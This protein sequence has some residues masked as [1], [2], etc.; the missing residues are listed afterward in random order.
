MPTLNRKLLLRLFLATL[1]LG[2]GLLLLHYVQSDR[3]KDALRWQADHAAENGRLDKA[4]LYMR[5]YLELRPEDHDAAVRLGELILKRGSGQKELT[6]ALFLYERVLR[7]APEREDVRRRLVDICVRLGRYGDGMIHA[8]ALLDRAPNES[9]LWEQ[10]GVCQAGLNQPDE[11]RASFEKAVA[12]DSARIRGYELLIDLLGRQLSRP[13]EAKVWADRMVAANPKVADA[14]IV[15]ARFLRGQRKLVECERDVEALLALEPASADG[16]LLRGDLWQEKGDLSKARAAFA[17]GMA[18]H[19]KDIRFYRA[20]SWL[21]VST[22]NLGASVVAL[23]RGI[24]ELPGATEL[25]APLGDLLVQQG[26]V[27]RVRSIIKKLEGRPNNG[28][29]VKYLRG[30]VLM[31]EGKWAEALEVLEGL[32]TEAVAMPALAAQVNFLMAA[33]HERRGDRAAQTES[34]ERVLAIDAGHVQTRLKFGAMRLATG[35]ID[36]AVKEYAAAARSP[37]APLGAR[38]TLGRLLIARGRAAGAH[39]DWHGVAEY[40]A[41]LREK[42]KTSAEPVLLA[43]E[44]HLAR[45]EPYAARSLLRAE[46]GKKGNDA[47]LWSV[48]SAVA[49]ESEGLHAAL[50]V[51][52]EAQNLASDSAELRLAK[53]RAWAADVKPGRA[54]RVRAAAGRLDELPET[55]Q[56]KLLAGLADVCASIH[57]LDGVKHFQQKLADRLP[58]D[59]VLRREL[60]EV[61]VKT[62]DTALAAGLRTEISR[63]A[64]EPTVLAVTE[65]LAGIEKLAPGSRAF[66]EAQ[67]LAGKV[68]AVSPERADAHFLAARLADKAGDRKVAAR[69]YQLA[70]DLESV[71]LGRAEA[72]LGFLLRA[73]EAAAKRRLEQFF[74]DPR[75]SGDAFLALVE[76][77]TAQV[78]VEKAE[79]CLDWATVLVQKSGV[80]LLWLA[81]IEQERGRLSQAL[82]LVE[83]AGTAAP[84]HVDT[85]SARVQLAPEKSEATLAAARS[86]LEDP[87]YYLLCAEVADVVRKAKPDWA[88]ATEKPGQ[89][90]AFVQA[91]MT[92]AL[93]RGRREEAIAVVKSLAGDAKARPED[94]AW[95]RRNLAMLAVAQG[96]PDVRRKA[97]LTLKTLAS[98]P[99]AGADDLRSNVNALAVSARHLQGADQRAAVRQAID[100]LKPFAAGQDATAKDWHHLAQFH[101]HA[102]DRPAEVAALKEALR[103]DETNLTY[104]VALADELLEDG[105]VA[106][107]QDLLPRLSEATDDPRAVSTAARIHG[108]ANRP[109]QALAVID[110]YA[111]AAEPGTADFVAR[112]RT[113]AAT[114][115]GV[116]RACSARH[117]PG[118]R[119]LVAAAIEKYRA[120]M[121][122][123]PG[124]VAP[125]SALLAFDGRAQEALDL[126]AGQKGQAQPRA[127]A[128]AGIAVLR[129]PGVTPRQFLTVK[130]W[131]EEALKETP[132]STA[133]LTGLAELHAL[134]QDLAAAVPL[135]RKVLKAE[136]DNIVALNNLAW[137]LAPRSETANEALRCVER[138]IDLVGPTGELLDTRARI[139]I[140]RG[141]VD[142]ATDDLRQALAQA[143]TPLRFF[144]L[145]LAQFA[146]LKKPDAL[147]SFKEARALGLD[148]KAIHPNDMPAYKVFASQTERQ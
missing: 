127:L 85:W 36:E 53:A 84:K 135:Y 146:Q 133:L 20:L 96:T 70:I 34:L 29:Q 66:A 21:E 26:D 14:Y 50:G 144:H 47:R 71:S 97:A 44:L 19:S 73:D 125:L 37:F 120:A 56:M 13:D 2:G 76:G 4:V 17:A 109:G 38:V 106:E 67:E 15:R 137:I 68:L 64:G 49:L 131:V 35:E 126:L 5:Q 142:R 118:A 48:L 107:A 9:P 122:D 94:A 33:C 63:L 134:R 87:A 110:Q 72:Q 51:I 65:S 91:S 141:D 93:A 128:E 46:A 42:Y 100:L 101:R 6:S 59:L 104:L 139:L 7:E 80:S 129:S 83:K 148:P 62:S 22:G 16:L 74:Y 27:E 115:D 10:L 124:A 90:R 40:I 43:A 82:A 145:A 98:E 61:V 112:A 99:A 54:E 41:Q 105:M 95:A 102:G 52:E 108:F 58:R 138:A 28:S 8:K 31:A 77:V 136:P 78:P 119:A 88:P 24:K 75:I 86:A 114:L 57:D 11:A 79:R 89:R 1:V 55:E 39:A 132:E 121:P 140:A 117:V 103:R 23:E 60:F 18:K 25:L 12:V 130:G 92:V 111:Q 123:T 3:A 143:R 45:Q 32:R 116:A 81:R 147:E 69:H 113:A 30:R